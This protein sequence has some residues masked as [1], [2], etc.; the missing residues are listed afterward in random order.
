LG[1][2]G[3]AMR[4]ESVTDGED[5]LAYLRGSDDFADR[6][7]HPLPGLVLLDLKMGRLNGLDVLAWMRKEEQFR[8][9]PVVVLSSSNHDV[10]IKRA[11]DLGA[12]SYLVKPVNFDALVEMARALQ[13][14]WFKLNAR[15][16]DPRSEGRSPKGEVKSGRGRAN[17]GQCVSP[18]LVGIG[19]FWWGRRDALP[20]IGGALLLGNRTCRLSFPRVQ[21]QANC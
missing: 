18:A 19:S 8:R 7:K 5:A 20:Y 2:A 16:D 4:L 1:K 13:N 6:E 3:T 12:N 10:D 11:C 9:V 14:Y 17:V 21:S 15:S